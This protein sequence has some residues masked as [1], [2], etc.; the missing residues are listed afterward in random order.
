MA[1]G[2]LDSE[3]DASWTWFCE[4]LKE[5]YGERK[6]MCVVSDRN[7]SIIEVV[8]DMYDNVP[9]YTCMWRLWGNVKKN[10]ESHMMHCSW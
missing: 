10:L 2:V 8:V 6:H 9:H 7:A 4:N 5:A 1:Y 3:N